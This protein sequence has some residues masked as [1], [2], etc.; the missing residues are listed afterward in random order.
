MEK[1][2]AQDPA[3][4]WLRVKGSQ[5]VR[6]YRG[7]CCRTPHI[8]GRRVPGI[9]VAG[10]EPYQREHGNPQQAGEQEDRGAHGVGDPATAQDE[11]GG[12]LEEKEWMI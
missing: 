7:S 9:C 4:G 1:E 3:N 8:S 12:R 6:A 5:A 10:L 2:A 11:A